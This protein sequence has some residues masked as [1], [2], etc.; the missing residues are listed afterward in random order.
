M[1]QNHRELHYHSIVTSLFIVPQPSNGTLFWLKYS[2]FQQTCHNIN[3]G[4]AIP[5]QSKICNLF[6]QDNDESLPVA[7][8]NNINS[9]CGSLYLC[10]NNEF[11]D[12]IFPVCLC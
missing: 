2:G 6:K 7:M 5:T 3:S 10:L 9:G 4:L 12:I 11:F 1:V 8:A